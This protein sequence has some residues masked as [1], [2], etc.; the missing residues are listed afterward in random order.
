M[1]YMNIDSQNKA[2]GVQ[3][4][5]EDPLC[6]DSF[7]FETALINNPLIDSTALLSMTLLHQ[8]CVKDL[9]RPAVVV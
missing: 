2:D 9:T 6:S 5:S 3:A 8:M 1:I 4:S 7:C